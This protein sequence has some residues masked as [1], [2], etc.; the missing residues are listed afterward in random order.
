M[1]SII[2]Q[3]EVGQTEI[4]KKFDIK[5]NLPVMRF[6]Y[7]KISVINASVKIST[8]K[9]QQTQYNYLSTTVYVCT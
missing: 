3:P 6:D 4:K 8:V 9:L 7:F 1:Y 5:Y 2:K